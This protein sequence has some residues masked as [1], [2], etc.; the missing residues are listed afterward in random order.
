MIDDA[1][2]VGIVDEVMHPQVGH[3]TSGIHQNQSVKG[4]F[5]PRAHRDPLICIMVQH[6]SVALGQWR[7]L[8]AQLGWWRGRSV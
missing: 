7:A 8:G 4:P 1:E 3:S 5:L 6:R 2:R